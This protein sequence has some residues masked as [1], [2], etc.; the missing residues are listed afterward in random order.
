MM[1]VPHGG[2]M[3]LDPVQPHLFSKRATNPSRPTPPQSPPARATRDAL[4][5]ALPPGVRCPTGSLRA[6]GGRAPLR[7]GDGDTG[8]CPPPGHQVQ[9]CGPEHNTTSRRATGQARHRSRPL[10]HSSSRHSAACPREGEVSERSGRLLSPPSPLGQRASLPA[11]PEQRV[12][13]VSAQRRH[14]REG[15]GRGDAV[16]HVER[17]ASPAARAP[18]PP[19]RGSLGSCQGGG[20]G[21]SVPP[22]FTGA[23]S[24]RTGW[25]R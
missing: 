6:A 15:R 21:A 3:F 12:R 14:H 22:A 17:G 13:D 9:P 20:E 24:G 2:N 5:C 10:C 25:G 8:S 4:G 11:G 1:H 7:G 18:S 16:F 19:A 23:R